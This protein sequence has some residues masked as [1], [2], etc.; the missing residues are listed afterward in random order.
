MVRP[1]RAG[2]DEPMWFITD[3]ADQAVILPVALALAVSLWRGGWM[4]GARTWVLCCGATLGG[5]GAAKLAVFAFGP[6]SLLPL[7]DSPSGHTASSAITWGGLAVLLLPRTRRLPLGLPI[8]AAITALIGATRLG[9]HVHTM[10][11]VIIGA[12]IGLTGT[13]A[14]ALALD[15]PPPGLRR[16]LLLGPAFLIAA[17]LHGY[18]LPAEPLLRTIGAA[19]RLS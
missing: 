1:G 5:L 8:A 2:T 6:F 19:L 9:L 16:S 17:A 14:L 7:L 4:K 12:A 18:R 3:F 10:P 15:D 13:L 11:D